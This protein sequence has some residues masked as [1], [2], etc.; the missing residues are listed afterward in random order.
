MSEFTLQIGIPLPNARHVAYNANH[1]GIAM[2]SV[3]KSVFLAG[4]AIAAASGLIFG[5]VFGLAVGCNISKSSTGP[6]ASKS[7][8]T[9][10]RDEFR[11]MVMGKSES[12]VMDLLGRPQK[13]TEDAWIYHDACID[14]ISNKI[15]PF[16]WLHFANGRVVKVSF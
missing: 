12:E 5:G 3:N 2:R 14:P 4:L 6:L 7:S 9:P 8:K 15:Q 16:T 1:G 13:T 11:K 10:T